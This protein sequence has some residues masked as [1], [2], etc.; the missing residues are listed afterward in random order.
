VSKEIVE[1]AAGCLRALVRYRYN[2]DQLHL[3]NPLISDLVADAFADLASKLD[4]SGAGLKLSTLE[5]GILTSA[6]KH[7]KMLRAN[8]NGAWTIWERSRSCSS[9]RD[10]TL[11]RPESPYLICPRERHQLL[12]QRH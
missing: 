6:E 1:Q 8:G 9:Q 11:S 4:K 5:Q 3:V 10:L 12:Q 7:F 2:A